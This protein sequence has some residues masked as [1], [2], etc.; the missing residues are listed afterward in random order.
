MRPVLDFV[1]K[2]W[3]IIASAPGPFFFGSALFVLAMWMMVR[4]YF[5][6]RMD[7]LETR[8]ALN[9]EQKQ[10]Y[11]R[12]L[13][14]ASPQE[15]KRRIEDLEATVMALRTA[16]QKEGLAGDLNDDEESILRWL[17]SHNDNGCQVNEVAIG[18]GL[19]RALVLTY[20]ERLSNVGLVTNAVD[21]VTW[22]LTPEGRV[23]VIRHDLD[24]NG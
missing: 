2:Q 5:R 9:V 1:S 10:E 16:V 21:Y 6:N 20:L 15:A 7:D 8:L 18:L 11:E 4:R 14:V 3:D 22:C 23:Y 13:N 24:S 17:L 19:D 12:V